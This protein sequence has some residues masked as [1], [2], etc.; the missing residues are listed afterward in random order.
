MLIDGQKYDTVES[1]AV[2][3]P[4]RPHPMFAIIKGAFGVSSSV[5]NIELICFPGDHQAATRECFLVFQALLSGV[6]K[7]L[8]LATTISFYLHL[9]FFQSSLH[10]SS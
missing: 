5:L 8:F 1:S 2:G 9:Y 3:L 4:S 7:A 10:V 6:N